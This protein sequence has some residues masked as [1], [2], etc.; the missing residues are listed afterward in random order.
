MSAK[1]RPEGIPEVD[2]GVDAATER[3]LQS[4]FSKAIVSNSHLL[5]K[6]ELYFT[7]FLSMSDMASDLVMVVSLSS[8]D[9]G[10]GTCWWK[11][12]RGHCA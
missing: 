6:A 7:A 8:I 4:Q 3:P 9:A 11:W 1:I 2:A 12:A 10:N 5:A